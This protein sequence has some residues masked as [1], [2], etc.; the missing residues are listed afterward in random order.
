MATDEL[1]A[2]LNRQNI[3]MRQVLIDCKEKLQLYR[4]E[5][6]GVYVGGVEYTEL[7]RRIDAALETRV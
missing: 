6:S 5:R 4:K 2:I 7:M 3:T 1:A